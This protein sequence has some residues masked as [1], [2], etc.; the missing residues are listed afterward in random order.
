MNL[1]N[2]IKHIKELSVTED[3]YFGMDCFRCV[4]L[5]QAIFF[6]AMYIL[7]VL[8]FKRGLCDGLAHCCQWRRR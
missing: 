5:R 3:P 4:M 7:C 8:P 6:P 2:N 1:Y